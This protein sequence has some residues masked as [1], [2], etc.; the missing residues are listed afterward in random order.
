MED[1]TPSSRRKLRR[2]AAWLSDD[3]QL[4]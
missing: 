3:L 4:N 2:K 1:S